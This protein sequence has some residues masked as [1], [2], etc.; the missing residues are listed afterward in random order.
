MTAI[1]DAAAAAEVAGPA[2]DLPL[3]DEDTLVFPAAW[4][5]ALHPRRGG[6]P[7]PALR[8]GAEARAAMDELLEWSRAD[9][10]RL[11]VAG[12]N[13]P[14]LVAAGQRWLAQ[15]TPDNPLGAASVGAVIDHMLNRI[16][17]PRITALADGWLELGGVA[18]ASRVIAEW[19][20]ISFFTAYSPGSIRNGLQRGDDQHG[21]VRDAGFR[22]CAGRVRAALAQV[23]D[24]E[25]AE[26]RAA[27][28]EYRTGTSQQR[29]ALAFLTPTETGWVDEACAE[30]SGS[31]AH[32]RAPLLWHSV[33]NLEQLALVSA[34]LT[35]W[36]IF[37]DLTMLTT[38]ADGVGTACA[39]PLMATLDRDTVDGAGQQR[40][41][42]FLAQLPTDEAMRLLIERLE[43][44]YF[45]GA[46]V[47][48]A[49]RFPVRAVRLLAEAADGTGPVA[50]I[51]A[52]LL[53]GHILANRDLVAQ[54]V[55]R[56][57]PATAQRVTAILDAPPAVA[58]AAPDQLPP[59]LADPPWLSRKKAA[60]PVAVQGLQRPEGVSVE[61][62][63]G[64]REEWL[65]TES[66][67]LK[68]WR[69]KNTSW[70][71]AAEQHAQGRLPHHEQCVLFV[72]GPAELVAPLVPAW[73]PPDSWEV[74][75]WMRQVIGRYQ[76][77]AHGAA[78]FVAARQPV[79]GGPLLAP[80]A[81]PEVADL[82][83][84]WL[85]RLKSARRLALAW[86]T[87]HPYTAAQ[88]LIP[89]AL[90]SAGPA[91]RAAENALRTL[92]TAGF[93]AE[94]RTA[95]QEYGVAAAAG[96]EAVLGADPLQLLPTR[97]PEPPHWADPAMLPP[98]LL[99]TGGA[100]PATAVRHVCTMLLMSKPGAVYAGVDLVRQACTP[101]SL[102]G[103]SWAL[104]ERWRG[105]GYPSKESWALDAL[106]WFGDD[107][108]VRRLSPMIRAWPGEGGHARASVG[109]EVLSDIGSSV[110]L[111]HLHGIAQKVKFAGLK[112]R[113]AKKMAEVADGLGLTAEQL[114]DR[115]VPDLGLDP[116]GS[117]VLD[118]GPRSFT[119]GFDE[120]L[121]PFVRDESGAVRKVLPKPG[122]KDDPVRGPAA[123]QRFA[124]L[125]KDV[126]TIAT[127]QIRRLEQAMVAQRH[128]T[129]AEFRELFVAHPVLWH[130]VR[131]LVWGVY[132]DTDTQGAG[133]GNGIR[134]AFR[135]AED[136]SFATVDDDT[137]GLADADVVGLVHPLH[138][139]EAVTAWAEVFAD[140]EILQPFAQ[141]GRPV[142]RLT[143]D[144]R[145]AVVLDRFGGVKFPTTKVFG[146]EHRGWRRGATAGWRRAGLDRACA[147][148]R[149]DDRRR[150]RAGHHRGRAGR[151][152]RAADQQ[153]VAQS[154]A[155]RQLAR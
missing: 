15:P 14:D 128:W 151:L 48:A 10:E 96:I 153:G 55:Q 69:M 115:L 114:A 75:V 85:N 38:L 78:L 149:P 35:G 27:L 95:A 47:A 65:A 62:R 127:D 17:Q 40:A 82:M 99:N 92:A 32:L 57:E 123:Y 111:M 104:F 45:P 3:P 119:V 63:P 138:L 139:G 81:S 53:R 60:K 61:W 21:S 100:L 58:D 97:I 19:A 76:V 121:K 12:Q 144:E 152:A 110:A 37:D 73:R 112:E 7:G 68:Y 101:Q 142:Y 24:A 137:F 29:M 131:R 125:K 8:S 103:F 146:L 33:G 1:K 86:L 129:G 54:V 91:R 67:Y 42:G 9:V 70:E 84:D 93:E 59:I 26:A 83:A 150:P 44:K 122:A 36:T 105:V 113:A 135:V 79:A 124:G 31:W 106:R 2:A 98:I 49:K 120:Q 126:R 11:F 133:A 108:T 25:Y 71:N 145:G 132:A 88:A 147:A 143:D 155:G 117:L 51:A 80:F 77:A 41:L 20:A 6:Q 107:D 72:D 13:D 64:E 4:R 39:A 28:A 43:R 109:L 46:V 134:T 30:L 34:H 102:A 118:Y 50:R 22:T 141:L 16:D 136:R 89:A 18:F 56:L 94:I 130:I 23:T 87:R 140:Y 66:T 52:E 148:R 74:E 5:R 116:A 90:G 154:Q